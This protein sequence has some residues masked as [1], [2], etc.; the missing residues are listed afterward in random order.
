MEEKKKKEKKKTEGECQEFGSG[1][2]KKGDTLRNRRNQ[3][4]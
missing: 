3:T 2:R 4:R 1:R